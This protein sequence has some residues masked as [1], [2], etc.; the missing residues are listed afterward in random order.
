MARHSFYRT[1]SPLFLLMQQRCI[2]IDALRAFDSLMVPIIFLE[3]EITSKI[4][5]VTRRL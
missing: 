5:L 1:I 4:S 3:H 2:R